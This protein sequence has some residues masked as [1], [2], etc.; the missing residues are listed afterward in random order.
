[1]RKEL[2]RMLDDASATIPAWPSPVHTSCATNS[3]IEQR[4]VAMARA[5][6]DWGKIGRLLGISRQSARSRFNGVVPTIP[7][8]KRAASGDFF[9]E[10]RDQIVRTTNQMKK[11]REYQ[12]MG[13]DV[14]AW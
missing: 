4:A 7:P 10:Q 5:G 8:H 9:Q 6:Y 12:R 3:W 2:D 1:M 14:V 11:D 13:D